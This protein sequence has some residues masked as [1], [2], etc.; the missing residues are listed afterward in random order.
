MDDKI[1]Q[2]VQK[3]FDVDVKVTLT[4]PDSQF[5]DYATNVAMQLATP[6]GKNPREIAQQIAQK[7][8]ESGDFSEVNVAGPGFI[9]LR[10]SDADVLAGAFATNVAAPID[11]ILLEYSCPNPFKEIHTGH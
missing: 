5:G 1:T 3:L 2:L 10:L 7:L 9:N 11:R 4:R 6:L 8:Q